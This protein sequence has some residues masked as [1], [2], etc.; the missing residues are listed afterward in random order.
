[1]VLGDSPEKVWDVEFFFLFETTGT[2]L[3]DELQFPILRSILNPSS[4]LDMSLQLMMIWVEDLAMAARLDGGF[5]DAGKGVNPET[6]S[7]ACNGCVK[8]RHPMTIKKKN[9]TLK[10]I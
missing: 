5:G 3:F 10:D 4:L 9:L 1:V 6:K 8:N 2:Q 7:S